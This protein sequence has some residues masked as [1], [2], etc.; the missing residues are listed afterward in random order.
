MNPKE[1]QS[2]HIEELLN[3]PQVARLLGYTTRQ[4]YELVAA[5]KLPYV[6]LFGYSLRFK[7]H[8]IL[9]V[10]ADSEVPA[11]TAAQ[12]KAPGTVPGTV[13]KPKRPKAAKTKAAKGMDPMLAGRE[14][15]GGRVN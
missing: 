12:S 3:V 4:I 2:V 9:A 1:P 11:K 5:K 10:I 6:K 15:G 7:K 14:A 8:V 13:K